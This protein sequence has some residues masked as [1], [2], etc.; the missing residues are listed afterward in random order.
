MLA[1]TRRGEMLT[2][3]QAGKLRAASQKTLGAGNDADGPMSSSR[4]LLK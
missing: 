2:K 4:S 1:E 3:S